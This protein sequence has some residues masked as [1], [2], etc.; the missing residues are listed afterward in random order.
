MEGTLS[1]P[2]QSIRQAGIIDQQQEGPASRGR[3]T[4]SCGYGGTFSSLLWTLSGLH[5]S[6]LLWRTPP[7]GKGAWLEAKPYKELRQAPAV[8]QDFP[9]WSSLPG[10]SVLLSANGRKKNNFYAL[11]MSRLKVDLG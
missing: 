1:R 8:S 10:T 6:V 4:L 7:Q 2:L 9:D 3:R 5:R 11:S